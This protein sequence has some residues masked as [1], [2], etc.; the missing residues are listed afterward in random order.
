MPRARESSPLVGPCSSSAPGS[1]TSGSGRSEPARPTAPPRSLRCAPGR[2][3]GRERASRSH[4]AMRACARTNAA[5]SLPGRRP[6]GLERLAPG[7]ERGEH[8]S[9][10]RVVEEKWAQL[11]SRDGDIAHR[12]GHNRRQEDTLAGQQVDLP[13]EPGGP[14]PDDLVPEA[15]RIPASPS[16]IAMKGRAGRRPRRARPRRRQCAPRRPQ[17]ASPVAARKELPWAG[18]SPS[19][20]YPARCSR[21]R[22]RTNSKTAAEVQSA[23]SGQLN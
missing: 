21:E 13:E 3:S 20:G 18:Q 6:P 1:R 23:V 7:D 9:A 22:D 2:A 19:G 14:L 10:E 8:G 12:L 15:S 4:S 11:L 17:P 5:R 16:R